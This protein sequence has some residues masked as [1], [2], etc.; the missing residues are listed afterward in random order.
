L[1]AKPP[2]PKVLAA[3]NPPP[4]RAAPKSPFINPGAAPP[5]A[6]ADL[7]T[8]GNIFADPAFAKKGISLPAKGIA[9]AT[10]PAMI[11]FTL[12]ILYINYFKLTN[13]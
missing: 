5:K 8:T 2:N 10:G 12:N 4:S 9:A 1:P 3:P 7:R 6:P 13:P 11:F